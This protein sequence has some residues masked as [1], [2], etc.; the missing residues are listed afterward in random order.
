MKNEA[1]D[2]LILGLLVVLFAS[3]YRKRA[4]LRLRCWVAGWILVL[5]HFPALLI[6]AV[7]G[8]GQE[9]VDSL[10]VSG[11]F[12]SG[13]CFLF[14]APVILETSAGSALTALGVGLPALIYINYV[15][16]GGAHQWLLYA[17][18]TVTTASGIILAWRFCRGRSRVWAV[19]TLA[20]SLGGIWTAVSLVHHAP[21]QGILALLF[22]IFLTFA[23]LYW[24]DFRR[25]STGVLTAILGLV[26]W[27]A[28]FPVGLI[29]D[30]FVHA[31]QIPPELWNVPKYFVAFGMILTLLEDRFLAAGRAI[32][33]YRLLFAAHP[34]PMWVQ[35][36]EYLR[37]LEVNDAA[38]KHYGYTREEFQS[39][40]VRDLRPN[41]DASVLKENSGTNPTQ[42]A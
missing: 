31:G 34:H 24:F 15:V 23:A 38:V 22:E 12:L 26:A 30:F 6:P 27:A 17:T 42:L 32:E 9:L 40:T 28:V 14:S 7:S 3:I 41:E 29:C 1:L 13:L 39:M 21:N 18:A 19:I 20:F 5:L 10:S 4:T 33:H 8:L 35:E 11:V 25:T 37:I 16:F 2:I 36:S